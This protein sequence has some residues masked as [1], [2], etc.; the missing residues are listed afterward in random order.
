MTPLLPL[1]LTHGSWGCCALYLLQIQICL[2]PL[3]ELKAVVD[4]MK[5]LGDY[6]TWGMGT[7]GA[8]DLSVETSSLSM[9]THYHHLECKTP[10]GEADGDGERQYFE[11]RVDVRKIAR[12]LL[13]YQVH[14][15]DV[16]CHLLDGCLMLSALLED[17]LMTHYL[18]LQQQEVDMA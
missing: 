1:I 4:R 8:L 3:R 2:P 14:P 13:T 9:A 12:F 16:Y 17:V 18:S 7:D 10:D 11:C 5:G 6:V 15:T